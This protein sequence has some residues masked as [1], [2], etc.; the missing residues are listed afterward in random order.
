[1][2]KARA[3]FRARQD[4]CARFELWDEAQRVYPPK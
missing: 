2:E 4:V 3:A 1:V